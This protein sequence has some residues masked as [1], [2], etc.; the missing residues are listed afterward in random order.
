MSCGLLPTDNHVA[1]Y[2]SLTRHQDGQPLLVA[3]PVDGNPSISVDWTEY[4]GPDIEASIAQIKAQL[5]K[6]KELNLCGGLTISDYGAFPVLSVLGVLTA[7]EEAE[8][9]AEV[10]HTEKKGNPSHTSISWK[11]RSMA[12]DQKVALQLSYQT[13]CPHLVSDLPQVPASDDAIEDTSSERSSLEL[14]GIIESGSL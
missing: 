14:P 2:C 9:I 8:A 5:A 3:F 11:P 1:R 6:A 4:Y 13:W 12:V 10:V 7:I